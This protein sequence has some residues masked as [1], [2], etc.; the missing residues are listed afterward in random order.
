MGETI[1]I[2]REDLA[3][4][5][6]GRYRLATGFY[7]PEEWAEDYEDEDVLEESET[8]DTVEEARGY[9]KGNLAADRDALMD[10]NRL[11]GMSTKEVAKDRAD[12]VGDDTFEHALFEE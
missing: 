10:L 5:L 4:F 11:L 12:E 7:P 8:F 3:E 1:T 9:A 6:L 2:D